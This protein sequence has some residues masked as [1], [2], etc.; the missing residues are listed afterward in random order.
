MRDRDSRGRGRVGSGERN[1]GA[2]LKEW[3]VRDIRKREKTNL[4]YAD[5][6]GIT[7]GAVNKIWRGATW[8]LVK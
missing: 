7:H 6:Y 1:S 3:Q 8:R 2:K 5:Q 4:E